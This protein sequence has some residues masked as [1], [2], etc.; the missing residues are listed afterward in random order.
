MIT[1]TSQDE[2]QKEKIMLSD[3]ERITY[4]EEGLRQMS[5]DLSPSVNHHDQ[6]HLD[7]HFS[8]SD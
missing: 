1:D 7:T 3:S 4:P 8:N 5:A 2:F 6:V